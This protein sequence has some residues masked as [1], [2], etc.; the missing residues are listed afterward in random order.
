[1]TSAANGPQRILI[2][3]H[4]ETEWSAAG[5][6]T[7]RTDIALSSAGQEEGRSLGPLLRSLVSESPVVVFASPLQRAIATAQLAI[8]R[9]TPEI[10][11]GLAEWDYGTIEGRTTSEVQQQQPGWDLFAD[12]APGGESLG[13]VVART[14]AFIAKMERMAKAGTVIVFGH[15]HAGRILTALLLDWPPSTA[16]RLY[17]DTASVAVI[18]RRH[19]QLVL[20]A[21]NQRA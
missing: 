15:G 10:A 18:D 5:R 6:H 9:A 12:G 16:A 21:W 20:R 14:T 2:V 13:Q 8:P 7:G 1:M 3:R 17:N 19:D 11:D 4:G